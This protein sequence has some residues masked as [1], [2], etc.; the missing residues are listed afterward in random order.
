MFEISYMIHFYIIKTD[1][2]KF[3]LLGQLQ[4]QNRSC[5]QKAHNMP[6][7]IDFNDLVIKL[8]R[9]LLINSLVA[10]VNNTEPC[11]IFVFK[12]IFLQFWMVYIPKKQYP[13]GQNFHTPFTPFFHPFK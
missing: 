3:A 13:R 5:D 11:S 2:K 9:Q 12:A 10:Y 7:V 1:E 6:Y 4:E 8:D